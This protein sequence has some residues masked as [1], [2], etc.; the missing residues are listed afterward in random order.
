MTEKQLKEL[1]FDE[2]LPPVEE[3]FR[4]IDE[5][6]VLVY[7]IVQKRIPASFGPKKDGVILRNPR[8]EQTSNAIL[9]DSN[10]KIYRQQSKDVDDVFDGS[11]QNESSGT[12]ENVSSLIHQS[13]RQRQRKRNYSKR[14]CRGDSRTPSSSKCRF[15]DFDAPQGSQAL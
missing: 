7:H 5:H 11:L 4:G 12:Q 2:R 8:N 13:R 9:Y 14:S 1:H 6:L 10:Q 3:V 15:I